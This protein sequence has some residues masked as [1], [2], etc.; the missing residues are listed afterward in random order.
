MKVYVPSIIQYSKDQSGVTNVLGV[1]TNEKDAVSELIKILV[2]EER[3]CACETAHLQCMNQL[4]TN[5]NNFEQLFKSCNEYDLTSYYLDS[6]HI[7]MDVF[8]LV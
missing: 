8:D 6:W 5:I 1:F 3:I 7:Q 2:T 4:I